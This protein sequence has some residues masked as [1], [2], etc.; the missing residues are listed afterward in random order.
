MGA[1]PSLPVAIFSDDHPVATDLSIP[2]FFREGEAQIPGTVLV[3]GLILP[4]GGGADHVVASHESNVV[5]DY[6]CIVRADW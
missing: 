1:N 2:E 4:G 6:L 5:I 3:G